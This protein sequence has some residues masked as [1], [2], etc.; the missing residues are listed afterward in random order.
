M[1]G[2]KEEK[3]VKLRIWSHRK[4]IPTNWK[5]INLKKEILGS[6]TVRGTGADR[7]VRPYTTSCQ[8]T[9]QTKS[10]WGLGTGG[11]ASY[12]LPVPTYRHKKDGEFFLKQKRKMKEKH[13]VT[14]MAV[15]TGM[16]YHTVRLY[17]GQ[18]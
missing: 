10:V 5:E 3:L 11:F 4:R 8:N 1:R 7:T 12:R 6:T 18:G 13:T 15:R 9:K 2:Y 17:G 14:L 16:D